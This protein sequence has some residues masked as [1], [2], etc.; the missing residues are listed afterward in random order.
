[1]TV[2]DTNPGSV[3]YREKK[4]PKEFLKAASISNEKLNVVIVVSNPCKFER[5]W[6]LAREFVVRLKDDPTIELYQL[7]LVYGDEE[8]QLTDSDNP[9]H[10]QLRTQH[11]IWHKE[12]MINVAIQKLLPKDWQ[13]VCWCD[14]DI[15]FDNIHWASDTLTLLDHFDVVQC[16]SHAIDMD[17][18]NNP[19]TLWQGGAFQYCNKMKRG[20]LLNYWHSGYVWACTRAFYDKMDG[21]YDVSI[22][23]SGDH[24]M[25]ISWL[26]SPDSIPG[27]CHPEYKKTI[28]VF[29]RKVKGARI[30][31]TPGVIKH[32]F[33]GHKKNRKYRERWEVLIRHQYN[34]LEHVE[35]DENGLLVANEKCPPELLADILEYFRERNE[36]E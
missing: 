27:D 22:L 11:P 18:S 31:Y 12:S 19:M 16:F 6:Q 5:R 33:H 23:G 9:N 10:L 28:E 25:F 32:Y 34:P 30:G 15:E 4:S 35:K 26:G 2:L 24:H 1:M 17:A 14:A 13:K 29:T 21:L 8:F 7:E 20:R 3:A 36:D